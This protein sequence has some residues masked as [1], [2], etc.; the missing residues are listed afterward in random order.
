[1]DAVE[2]LNRAK[3][4]KQANLSVGRNAVID[5]LRAMTM[6]LMIFVNDLWSISGYPAWLGH[7]KAMEDFMGLA[8]VV[9][10]CFLIVVGLSIPYAITSRRNKG[11][12][13]A[14]IVGHIIS[15]SVALILMGVFIVN[16]EEFGHTT[17]GISHSWYCILMVVAF[18]LIWNVY[19][20][21]ASV[22]G[23]RIIWAARITGV[24]ILALLAVTYRSAEGELFQSSWWGILGIIG[25]TYLFCAMAYLFIGNSLTK[26]AGLFIGLV[27][28]CVLLSLRHEGGTILELPDPNFLSQILE[29]LHIGNGCEAA[30]TC[31]GVIMG[32][33]VLKYAQGRSQIIY[34]WG[35]PAAII[36]LIAGLA[37]NHYFITSKIMSTAPWL[38]Y[39]VA[40]LTCGYVIVQ[41]LVSHRMAD[42]FRIV[43]PAG[44]ATL[45]CYIM[46]YLFYS[47][48]D[49]LHCHLPQSW[50]VGWL[51][52]AICISFSFLIIWITYAATLLHIKLKV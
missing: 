30:L 22:S 28:L 9:F 11:E 8:D 42:V 5:I 52:I 18:L 47:V 51:G 24:A 32:V 14:K 37:C 4:N 38:F 1:M 43:A 20:R 36:A 45:T 48:A 34:L 13:G 49:I 21:H 7:S 35:I 46:P 17:I 15:R 39:N 26:L 19:P 6:L 16:S 41:F 25:W 29:T 27:T 12:D 50:C 3:E 40:I 33:F 23:Q 44:T 31:W 10:P 2:I